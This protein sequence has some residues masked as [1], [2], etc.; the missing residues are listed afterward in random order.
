MHPHRSAEC[1]GVDNP[2]RVPF[3]DRLISASCLNRHGRKILSVANDPLRSLSQSRDDHFLRR[4]F[5][6]SAA[7][8]LRHRIR[9]SS[10][11]DPAN[12]AIGIEQHIETDIERLRGEPAGRVA[13]QRAD[14]GVTLTRIGERSRKAAGLIERRVIGIV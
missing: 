8:A 4:H 7:T 10:L 3:L 12:A 1:A 9:R 14:R 2:L 6:F 11:L 5:T 13:R